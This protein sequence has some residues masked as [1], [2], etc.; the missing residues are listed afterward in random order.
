MTPQGEEAT[1]RSPGRVGGTRRPEGSTSVAVPVWLGTLAGI[2]WRLVAVVALMVVLV[3]IAILLM[4]VTVTVLVAFLVAAFF[5]PLD[6]RL[7]ARGWAPTKA[8]SATSVVALVAVLGVGV[9]L[10][11]GLAPA[12]ADLVRYAD[13]GADNLADELLAFGF[14]PTAVT[15]IT[16]LLDALV[17]WISTVIGSALNRVG[18]IGTVIILGGFLTFY[19]LQSGDRAWGGVARGLAGSHYDDLTARAALALERVSGYL[20]GV[21]VMAAIDGVSTLVFLTLLGVP[22]APPL[23]ALVFLGGAIPYLG[24][25]FTTVVVVLV[26]WAAQGVDAAAILLALV[27]AVS[28]GQALLVSPRVYGSVPRISPA[29]VIVVL[30]AGATLFGI[31]GLI[32]AVPLVVALSTLLP[33]VIDMLEDDPPPN[34]AETP[35]PLWLDRLGQWSWRALAVII[36]LAVAITAMLQVPI[37]TLPA[38]LA[39]VLAATLRPLLRK[40]KAAGAGPTVAAGVATVGSAAI[41]GVVVGFTLVSI[42]GSASDIA[43]RASDGAAKAGLGGVPVDLVGEIGSTMTTNVGLT[44]SNLLGI[45]L[46]FL[47]VMFITFFLLRDG[48]RWWQ[49]ILARVPENRRQPASAIVADSADILSGYMVGTGAISLFAG[50]TAWLM[51]TLLG[52]PLALPIGV[53]T[54]FLSFIPYIGDLV[55]TVL[56]FL[57]A[58]AVGSTSDIILMGVYTLVINVVQ[59]N[60]VAP[61]VYKRTVSLPAAIVLLSAPAGAAIGGMMGMFLIVPFLGVIAA[62]WRSVLRL[63]DATREPPTSPAPAP[64][65]GPPVADPAPGAPSPAPSP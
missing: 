45:S 41:V 34:R 31:V 62:T 50:V 29:L 9:L 52:L 39:G 55:A 51:M 63:F 14:S 64:S 26:T 2:S 6:A 3:A 49:L 60:I 23:A 1:S 7:R 57:V 44:I 4:T 65:A 43:A 38:I 30:P 36:A 58:V 21:F 17:Q 20:R 18:D 54:F 28:V 12:I 37:V 15:F 11:I 32:V 8:A 13:D 53:L 16:S 5:A 47:M 10:V 35:I 42:A 61:L 24:A 25:I 48:P 56:A 46:A 59:G 40:L 22:L 19:V 27:V 33:A